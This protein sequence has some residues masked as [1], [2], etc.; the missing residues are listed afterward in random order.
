MQMDIEKE[1]LGIFLLFI[2][3]AYFPYFSYLQRLL[4]KEDLKFL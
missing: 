3:L 1:P 2:F 4:F